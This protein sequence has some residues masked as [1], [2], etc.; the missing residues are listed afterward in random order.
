MT[1]SL[2]ESEVAIVNEN[3]DGKTKEK[4]KTTTTTIMITMI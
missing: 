2:W 1:S 4:K 3:A